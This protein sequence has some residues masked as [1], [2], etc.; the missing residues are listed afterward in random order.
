MSYM[1]RNVNIFLLFMIVLMLGSF[2]AFTV[3]Y[4]NTYNGLSSTFLSLKGDYEKTAEELSLRRAQLNTTLEEYEV[5]KT[6]E[7][8]LSEKYSDIRD[9]N[10]QLTLDLAQTRKNLADAELEVT[11]KE[12]ELSEKDTKIN[13]LNSQIS[14]IQSQVS[15]LKDQVKNLKDNLDACESS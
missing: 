4:K 2:A 12:T 8:S 13:D 1:Q 7:Q 10:S 11:Q 9:V 14:S 6:R 15:S 3:Y 5:K